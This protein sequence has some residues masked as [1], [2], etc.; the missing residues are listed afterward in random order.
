MGDPPGGSTLKDEDGPAKVR[1]VESE[2]AD[3]RNT[4]PV[5]V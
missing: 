3:G 1:T 2:H 4:H 5:A